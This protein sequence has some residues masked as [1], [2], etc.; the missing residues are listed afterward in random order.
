MDIIKVGKKGQ[1]SI[2]QGVLRSLAIEPGG[3][4]TLD[5]TGDG[6]IVLRPAAVYAVEMYGDDRIAEIEAANSDVPAAI[7]AKA[8]EQ[9]AGLHR[10]QGKTRRKA[11]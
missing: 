4:L 10:P 8:R 1:I 6:A 9:L 11:A 2:P 7:V 5:V 3:S